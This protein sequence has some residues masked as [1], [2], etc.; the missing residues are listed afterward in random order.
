MTKKEKALIKKAIQLIHNSNEY[1]EGMNILAKLVGL[2]EA[3][4]DT[5]KIIDACDVAS[6]KYPC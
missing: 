6:G 1:Y 2:P 5:V 3:K 4:F